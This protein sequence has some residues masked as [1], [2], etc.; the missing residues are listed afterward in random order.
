MRWEDIRPDD[1]LI[2]SLLDGKYEVTVLVR[3]L[4]ATY[5]SYHP[6]FERS[7]GAFS[8]LELDCSGLFKGSDWTSYYKEHRKRVKGMIDVNPEGIKGGDTISTRQG[9][10]KCISVD[11]ARGTIEYKTLNH[12]IIHDREPIRS[13][14]LLAKKDDRGQLSFPFVQQAIEDAINER[15]IT[16]AKAQRQIIEKG[17]VKRGKSKVSDKDKKLKELL[18]KL[19]PEQL[20]ELGLV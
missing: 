13:T 11:E 18:K 12:E 16:L 10:C 5:F 6:Y 4:K 8:Y 17:I 15:N 1:I 7:K 19:S 14:R 9:I 3:H 2:H 20:K